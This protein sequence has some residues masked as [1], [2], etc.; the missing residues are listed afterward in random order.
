MK[1]R[2]KIIHASIELFNEKGERN[3]T[4]NHIAAHLGISP[5]NLYY[6]FRN[7]EDIIN[8]IYSEYADDLISEFQ[9]LRETEDPL[10]SI[11]LYMDIVF[12][13][14]SKFRFFYSNLPVLLAKNPAL[15]KRYSEIQRQI[16]QRVLH[17]LHSLSDAG[18]LSIQDDEYEDLTCLL[19]LT[20]TFW[21][22]YLQ[23]QVDEEPDINDESIYDG[24]LKIFALLSPYVTSDARDA[25][26]TARDK[27]KTLQQQAMTETAEA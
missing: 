21:L 16:K 7:K 24:L 4:T 20:T 10:D 17:M 26:E 18:I 1:T 22:S 23:T 12:Q 25:F 5:G 2:D 14:I 3:I 19:R 13:L 9:H 8:T 15:K 6:H 27:Y 11:L